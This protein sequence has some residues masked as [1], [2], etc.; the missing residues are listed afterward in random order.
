MSIL[1]EMWDKWAPKE[2]ILKAAKRVGIS[3]SGLN[4]DHMQQDKFQQAANIMNKD[5]DSS[6]KPGPSTPKR[7]C[8][9]SLST[10]PSSPS[11]LPTT[12]TSLS[13]LAKSKH[14]YGSLEYWKFMC[15]KYK[16]IIKEGY[17]KSLRLEDIPGLLTVNKVKPKDLQKTKNTRV[18]NVHGSMEAEDILS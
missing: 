16:E 8:T 13:K 12:P 15:Q 14:K 3:K 2:I 7:I 10:T 5:Q 11:E 17:E 6:D 4:V 18:T 1:G 9:R